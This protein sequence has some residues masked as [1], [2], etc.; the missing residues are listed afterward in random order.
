MQAT[1][2]WFADLEPLVPVAR[3]G[4]RLGT[5]IHTHSHTHTCTRLMNERIESEENSKTCG[6][7]LK[8]GMAGVRSVGAKPSAVGGGGSDNS[9][10]PKKT[11]SAENSP[12][13]P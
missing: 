3:A 11:H 5:Y 10:S 8:E 13:C 9:L 2:Q 12:I 4:K 1:D 6:P 7:L